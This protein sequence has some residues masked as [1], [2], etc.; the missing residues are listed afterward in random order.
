VPIGLGLGR[1]A[2]FINGELYGRVTDLPWGIV[3]PQGGPKPRHPS[4]LY[5]S[6][7]EGPVLFL[8]LWF[9]AKRR[10]PDGVVLAVEIIVY[11]VLR[12]LIEFVREPDSQLGFI[13]GPFSMGQVMCSVMILFGIGLL[14]YSGRQRNA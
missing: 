6:I 2:N 9:V 4:Q 3:F 14:V 10:P 11:G 13:L 1:I 8:I 7:L 12:F 5:E